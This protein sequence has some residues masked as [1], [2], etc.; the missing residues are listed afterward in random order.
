MLGAGSEP[1]AHHVQENHMKAFNQHLH[2]QLL[3]F[4]ISRPWRLPLFG[5]VLVFTLND[6]EAS[7][8]N[9]NVGETPHLRK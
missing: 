1:E 8:Q 5:L 3:P 9:L 7:G 4:L 2:L 6:T